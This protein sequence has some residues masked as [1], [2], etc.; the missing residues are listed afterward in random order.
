[1]VSLHTLYCYAMLCYILQGAVPELSFLNKPHQ[2]NGYA[3]QIALVDPWPNGYEWIP[4]LLMGIQSMGM[5]M[6]LPMTLTISNTMA[7][8]AIA[9][10]AT[11]LTSGPSTLGIWVIPP[12][13]S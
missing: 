12:L 8:I 10:V 13:L 3:D 11:T 9:L 6:R 5:T 4:L 2:T 7:L 1:M